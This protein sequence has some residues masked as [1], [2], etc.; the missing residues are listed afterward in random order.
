MIFFKTKASKPLPSLPKPP[1]CVPEVRREKSEKITK[2]T[3]YNLQGT[4]MLLALIYVVL[5][6]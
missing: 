4:V 6:S 1:T 2:S 3:K 5:F